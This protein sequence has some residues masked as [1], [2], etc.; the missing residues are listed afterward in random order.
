MRKKLYI[1]VLLSLSATLINAQKA[2]L[3]TQKGN[4]VFEKVEINA[5]T[6]E[7]AWADHIRKSTQLP[8]SIL[9]SIPCGTYTV[10]VR[11]I[12]DKHGNIGQVT[13]RNNPGYGLATRAANVV[14]TYNGEWKAATQCGRNVTSY[15]EQTV[16]F[17]IPAQ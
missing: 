5:G 7:K 13:A 11:F 10:S 16:T 3:N 17:I 6:N 15:K 2:I 9:K 12:V 4:H 1:S 14:S 8:D